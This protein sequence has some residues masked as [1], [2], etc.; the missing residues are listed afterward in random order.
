M[1][2]IQPVFFSP[3]LDVFSSVGQFGGMKIGTCYI[4]VN[5]S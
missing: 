3:W 5:R 2:S 4:G 1:E